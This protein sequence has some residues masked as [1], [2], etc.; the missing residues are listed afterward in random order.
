MSCQ[1][2]KVSLEQ[3]HHLPISNHLS[4][5]VISQI[6]EVDRLHMHQNK[7]KEEVEVDLA[8]NLL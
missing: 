6:R 4:Q 3:H 5:M 2:F 1:V 7:L 8:T